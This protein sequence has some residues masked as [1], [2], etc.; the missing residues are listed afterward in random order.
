MNALRPAL[1]LALASIALPGCMLV[2]AGAA[3]AAGAIYIDGEFSGRL[4]ASPK[5]VADASKRVL[6]DLDIK[7]QRCEAS[8]IDGSV[9]GT[10]ALE[11]EIKIKIEREDETTSKIGIR[12]GT[13][14][15]EALSRQ[16]YDKIKARL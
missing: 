15:D 11:R 16:I 12:V 13:W 1:F 6:E 8:S 3:G 2:V 10:S 14:G 4:E 5:Q 7:V 9:E